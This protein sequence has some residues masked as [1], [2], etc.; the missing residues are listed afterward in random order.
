MKNIRNKPLNKDIKL[1]H[2]CKFNLVKLAVYSVLVFNNQ[3]TK[4]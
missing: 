2:L 4:D 1:R 3:F